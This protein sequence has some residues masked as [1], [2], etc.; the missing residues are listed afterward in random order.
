MRQR[1]F[2]LL[3]LACLVL[4]PLLAAAPE[5]LR[6]TTHEGVVY[7][8]DQTWS[9]NMSLGEDVTI[10]SGATLTIEADTHL[11]VTEDVTITIDGDLDIQGTSEEPV[12]IWGSWVAETS[13][14]AR[15]QG[16]LLTSGS[17]GTV[18]HA[19]IS[20][21]RGGFD[22]ESGSTLVIQSTNLTDSVIGVWAKGDV[23]GDGFVCESATTS[24]LRVDGTAT[25]TDVTSTLSAEVVHVHNGGNAN[26]GTVTSS[27]DADVIVIDDGST[28]S[29]NAIA[30]N[31]TRLIR[32]SGSV[33]ATVTSTLTG[34]GQV[35]VEADALSGLEVAGNGFCGAECAISSL[36]VGSVEDVE[37]TSLFL[38]CGDSSP[39]IDAQIDGELAF[40]GSGFPVSEVNANGT[41][42][43][44]RGSG[45]VNIN[46]MSVLYSNK[47]FDVSG[48]G[49]LAIT[50]S[51]LRFDDGGSI[52][53]WSLEID[54]TIMLAEENGFVLIDVDTTL[55][56]IEL[57]R[58]YSSSD[59]T[60]I[61]IRAVW[62][63]IYLDD[64]S[65]MGWNEGFR[66][67][68][69]CRIT[70]GYLSSGGGGRNAG[71]GI[72]IDG[73]SAI[74]D[75]LDTS[76]SDVGIDVEDGYVHLVEWN[77]DIAHR[78]YGIELSN[79]ANAIIRDM[80]GSTSIGAYDGFGDGTLL[81]GSTGAPNL[82]VSVEEQFTESTITVT[83]LVGVW[84]S[85]AS[86]HAHGFSEITDPFGEATLPLLSS[87]SFVEAEDPTSG[88]GSSAT[89]SPPGAEIQIA[90]VPGTGDWTIPAGV[91]ARLVNGEFVLDGDLTIESTA[92]LM[93][94]DATL[95]MPEDAILTIQSNGQLKGDNGSL[96]GGAGALTAGVPLKGEGQGLTV[97]SS[98]EF[99]CYDPWTWV[100]TSL[101]GPLHL[102]QDCELI[103]DGGHVSGVL[104]M[105]TD[106]KLTQRSHL[107]VRVIDAGTAVEGANVSIG[108]DVQQTD[109]NGE[110]DAWYTWRVVDE[111][112][113]TDSSNQQTVV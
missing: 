101:N 31:F 104:T 16:F 80:P 12:V 10:A 95:S 47:L 91:D 4:S 113:E 98:L 9:G 82:A 58:D 6:T 41:F 77:V 62:S 52:S 110:V 15:W 20:D 30:D 107:T 85:G 32:G 24:C 109:A 35:L 97:S 93:L 25:L 45:T 111:N 5:A 86:V 49:E 1:A 81:W 87:G 66:C 74:I 39:C 76:A 102:N 83:D 13:I 7:T 105:D 53:G 17:S 29:G 26:L 73:G 72:T 78:S 11:N 42:A 55:T 103:L 84:I 106:A 61:G 71:S 79:D 65:L 27:N 56:L 19:D 100:S 70:G 94:I 108:G 33:T 67:E 63:D 23:S 37:F 44:L 21:S 99:T 59:S 69:E 50:D 40:V 75:T 14:Q 18:A 43:R 112:G 2:C 96:Q 22:V 54:N 89:I 46:E 68:S 60:S 8:T 51:T 57:H 28:F 36:L 64:V 90:I 3:I 92:S 48:S 38:T 88:M 34:V